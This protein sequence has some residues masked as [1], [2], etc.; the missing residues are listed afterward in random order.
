MHTLET[1]REDAL[2]ID[3]RRQRIL[4]EVG[5]PDSTMHAEDALQGVCRFAI[6]QLAMSGCAVTL[7]SPQSTIDVLASAGRQAFQLA[8]LQFTLGEGPCLD[9][10]RSGVPVLADDLTSV[11][12]RWP[13]FSPAAVELGVMA[14][15]S[16]PMQVGAAGLGTLDLSRYAQGG[17]TSEQLADALVAADIVT[18]AV[19]MLQS[20]AD[21]D[22]L[23]QLLEPAQFDRLVVHQ[24]TGMV[25]VQLGVAIPDAFASLRARAFQT[26]RTISNVASD[27]VDRKDRFHD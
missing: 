14:E 2:T 13:L 22:A 5:S 7:M 27:V 26:G 15:F 12:G 16:L 11:G 6:E 17:L 4:A 21:G 18:E 20:S 8:E 25:A 9:A 1:C 24:A 23:A 19:L 3:G 10:H